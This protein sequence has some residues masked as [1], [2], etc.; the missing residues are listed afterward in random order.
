MSEEKKL[1]LPETFRHDIVVQCEHCGEFTA[2]LD[3]APTAWTHWPGDD[4]SRIEVVRN[5]LQFSEAE[6]KS[7]LEAIHD[8]PSF[9]ST[10]LRGALIRRHAREYFR[11]KAEADGVTH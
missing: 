7:L 4:E 1:D 6:Y 8:D 5:E 10:E 9:L 3:I 11:E 2:I